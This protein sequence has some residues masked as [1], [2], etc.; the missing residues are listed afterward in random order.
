MSQGRK[1]EPWS[2]QCQPLPFYLQ[3]PV[4][5]LRRVSS[6]GIRGMVKKSLE[7]CFLS[8]TD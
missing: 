5:R 2:S 3:P 6:K 1:A 8:H 7:L 4:Q